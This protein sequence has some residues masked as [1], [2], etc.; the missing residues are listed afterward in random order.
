[1]S[2]SLRQ[3][4]AVGSACVA[5]VSA[6]GPI[7]VD[8]ALWPSTTSH[9]ADYAIPHNTV[10][11]LG[12]QWTE[13]TETVPLT[14]P[15]PGPLGI[16]IGVQDGTTLVQTGVAQYGLGMAPFYEVYPAPP[17]IPT[18][19]ALAAPGDQIATYLAATSPTTWQAWYEDLTTGAAATWTLPV[20]L[21]GPLDLS[22]TVEDAGDSPNPL[23]PFSPI[24][25][26]H[27]TANGAGAP[28]TTSSAVMQQA[29]APQ[30]V[31]TASASLPNATGDGFTITDT[32][33]PSAPPP[34]SAT[35]GAA[36]DVVYPLVAAP[37]Q[38]LTLLGGG[39]GDAGTVTWQGQ[40]L[41]V[42]QW[43]PGQI[44]VVAP[45]V[46][47]VSP[48]TLVV[49]P[50]GG[51]PVP[52]AGPVT[53]TPA[54]SLTLTAGALWTVTGTAFGPTLGSVR[55]AHGP[56]AVVAWHP[57][58]VQVQVPVTAQGA[59]TV[60]IDVPG[61]AAWTLPVTIQPIVPPHWGQLTPAARFGQ[62]SRLMGRSLGSQGTVDWNGHRLVTT[63]WT[64]TSLQIHW[65]PSG[66]PGPHLLVIHTPT[67]TLTRSISLQSAAVAR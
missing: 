40:T 55:T 58:A 54:P 29:M 66:P 21:Q 22:W 13:P 5:L 23:P 57:G 26:S 37:G 2:I 45:Q 25:F 31:P 46:S 27:L 6:F 43:S 16:W 60:T 18:P 9:W 47:S 49:T 20:S 62:W 34:A 36:I 65:P 15:V 64:S 42:L 8:A 11:A 33:T 14:G 50:S 12:A 56:W 44:T 52:F 30:G 19:V 7:P 3:R 67:G 41:S 1:M 32:A 10:T 4:F 39:F 59:Q 35:P 53:L 63:H 61:Q 17:V 28:L 38:V 24:V 48:G 51:S